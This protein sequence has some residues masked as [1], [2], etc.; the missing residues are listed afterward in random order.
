[1]SPDH[2]VIRVMRRLEIDVAGVDE[3]T[4]LRDDLAID[5]TELVEIAVALEATTA[6]KLDT[7]EV[8]ALKTVRDLMTFVDNAP[9]QG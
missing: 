3:D 5:S 7:D 4:N 1:M 2:V 6:T 8:L 9:R